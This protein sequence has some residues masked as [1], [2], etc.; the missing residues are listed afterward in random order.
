MKTI[1]GYEIKPGADLSGK[2]LSG[3]DLSGKDLSGADFRFAILRDTDF[4]GAYLSGA[5]FRY[6]DLSGAEFRYA[7]LRGA[8]LTGAK[9]PAVKVDI[10]PIGTA[11]TGWKKCRGGALV[12]LTVPA[13]ADRTASLVGRS[14]RAEFAVVKAVHGAEEGVSIYDSVTRYVVGETVRPNGFND[15]IRIEGAK[16]IH[17]FETREEAERYPTFPSRT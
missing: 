6:A 7:I 5:D 13:D 17:F 14:C 2:D 4:L 3:K 1:N 15:D 9:L 10:P 11:F 12:E 16:G 8:I